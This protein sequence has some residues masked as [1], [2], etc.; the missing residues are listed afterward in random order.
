MSIMQKLPINSFVFVVVVP[1]LAA[2]GCLSA[3][4]QFPTTKWAMNDVRYAQEHREPYSSNRRERRAQ[5]AWDASFQEGNGG[6]YVGGG[7][8]AQNWPVATGS[9]GIFKMPTAW[10]TVRGGVFGMDNG[11][12][13][14][15][16]VEGE[17]RLH[18]PTRF[19][20]YVG[21]AGDAGFSGLASGNARLPAHSATPNHK[22]S[23]V[24][25]LAAIAPETGVSYWL[26]SS[27]R[28][29]AGAGYYFAVN[30]T[31][32]L[33]FTM[34][35]E[36][37]LGDDFGVDLFSPG[38]TTASRNGSAP[39]RSVHDLRHDDYASDPYFVGIHQ[40]STPVEPADAIEDEPGSDDVRPAVR[41]FDS[42]IEI[43]SLKI[44]EPNS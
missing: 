43:L 3:G 5:K 41:L 42:D 20:P 33:L 36:F 32:F 12:I 13:G 14:V 17:V 44:D 30:Q 39:Q 40:P 15:G 7:S 25:G 27:T 2:S 8:T 28:L 11:G 35:L 6:I 10:S 22:V 31:D 1:L 24:A 23:K 4:G 19:T 9:M 16:G 21:L 29:N 37:V 26:N 18:A 38:T 34:S